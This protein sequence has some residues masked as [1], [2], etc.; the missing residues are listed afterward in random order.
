MRN[1]NFCFI[2]KYNTIQ[3][4][5]NFL[6]FGSLEGGGGYTGR[7]KSSTPHSDPL[8]PTVGE[9]YSRIIYSGTTPRTDKNFE[10]STRLCSARLYFADICTSSAAVLHLCNYFTKKNKLLNIE[11]K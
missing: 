1:F 7:V 6:F 9:L 3:Y 10:I 2:N 5:F 11:K 4:F 8:R